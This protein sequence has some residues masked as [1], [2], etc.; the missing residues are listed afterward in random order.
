MDSG[1][2]AYAGSLYQYNIRTGFGTSD[3]DVRHAF[4]GGY[5]ILFPHVFRPGSRSWLEKVAGG[6]TISGILK[7]AQPDFRGSGL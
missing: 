4:Q 2:N 1:S 3:Y 5:G 7:C 6:W